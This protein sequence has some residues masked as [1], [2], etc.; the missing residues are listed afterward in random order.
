MSPGR[1][2]QKYGRG[3][4]PVYHPSV[5]AT[6]LED[7]AKRRW[8]FE[9][10]G[11]PNCLVLDFAG[12]TKRLGPIN[13]P[14]IP[15]KRGNGTGEVP[16]KL[17]DNCGAYNHISA[18]VCIECGI[19]FVLKVKTRAKAGEDEIIK[20]SE[21]D[22]TMIYENVLQTTYRIHQKAGKPPSLQCNYFCGPRMYKEW[23]CFQHTGLAKHAAHEWWRQRCAKEPPET[24]AEAI[25][26]V[27]H[28]RAP[29]QLRVL[30][31]GKYPQ[32]Q[33]CVF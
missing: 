17:C 18:R 4:R 16:I 25:A 10:G 31:G 7:P 22:V 29:K 8:A 2:V 15:Q 28:L 27:P 24:V 3:T 26:H 14:V 11:K 21:D 1:H 19:E 33:E 30:V 12:N 5:T 20:R 9:N 23:V 32:I 6:E 13:D